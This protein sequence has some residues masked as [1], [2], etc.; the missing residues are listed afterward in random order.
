MKTK[1]AVFLGI[2]ACLI[3]T[4]LH[5]Y[6]KKPPVPKPFLP[7]SFCGI[8][9]E[10]KIEVASEYFGTIPDYQ[11]STAWAAN[12]MKVNEDCSSKF[13]QLEVHTNI[14]SGKPSEPFG[15][16]LYDVVISYTPNNFKN[17]LNILAKTISDNTQYAVTDDGHGNK[18]YDSVKN[19]IGHFS[20]KIIYSTRGETTHILDCSANNSGRM[21]D[22]NLFY[23]ADD[24]NIEISGEYESLIDFPIVQSFTSRFIEGVRIKVKDNE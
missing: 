20:R 2:S 16:N 9:G 5:M 15:Q 14:S 22:C 1:T 12:R 4:A 18:I 3:F 21:L 23:I 7:K 17:T 19:E 13:N 6:N 24:L 11:G 8:L 10:Q